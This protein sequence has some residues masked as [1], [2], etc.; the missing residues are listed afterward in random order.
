MKLIDEGTIKSALPYPVLIEKLRHEFGSGQVVTPTRSHIEY[1]GRREDEKSTLLVM[2]SWLP[3]QTLGMKVV[4]VTPGNAKAQ[5]PSINGVYLLF[6]ASTG[7]CKYIFDAR[8]LTAKRTAAT[9]ALASTFLSNENSKTLLM[10]GT[11]ALSRELIQAHCSVRPIER[12]MIWG[13]SKAN[14]IA[15]SLRDMN[16]SVEVVEDLAAA[17]KQ[18][19]IISCATLSVSPLIDARAIKAGQHLDL[20]GAYRKDMREVNDDVVKQARIYIDHDGALKESGELL[21]P[22]QQ[23][24]ITTK[25]IQGNLFELCAGTKAGRQ[26]PN[27]VTLFKS[28]GHAME[29]LVAAQL[30]IAEIKTS[31]DLNS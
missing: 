23:G 25:D 3:Y 15:E 13:R 12:V 17:G 11:G 1:E 26:N 6:D 28:V 8:A 14:I 31:A 21:R 27:D 29:D 30:V 4:T 20:V 19:D 7:E 2:P 9:S 10:V 5:L 24:L 18:A 16:L 22:L